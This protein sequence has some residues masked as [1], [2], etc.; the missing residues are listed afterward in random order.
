MLQANLFLLQRKQTLLPE[1]LNANKQSTF[2]DRRWGEH[3]NTLSL[4]DKMMMRF[5]KTRM[6]RCFHSL[7]FLCSGGLCYDDI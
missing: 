6:V 7:A 2:V 1:L 4:E 5:Q 3:D